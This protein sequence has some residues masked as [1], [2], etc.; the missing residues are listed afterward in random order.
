VEDLESAAEARGWL[1]VALDSSDVEDKD[2]FL[3]LCAESFGLPEWFGMNWDALEESLADLDLGGAPGVLVLWSG[4]QELADD[5]PREFAT[6]LDVLGSAAAGWT[7]DGAAG[8]V[9]V[10]G[11][12]ELDVPDLVAHEHA[13]ALEDADELG[14]VVLDEDLDPG[15]ESAGDPGEDEV[16]D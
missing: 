6:A 3:E 7:R 16:R 9:L 2:G 5:A 12:G 13:H 11:E 15:L 10:L 14:D 1:C 8:G 4:W